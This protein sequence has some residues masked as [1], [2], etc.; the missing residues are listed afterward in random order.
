MPKAC[1]SAWGISVVL[2]R[3]PISLIN[4]QVFTFDPEFMTDRH[5]IQEWADF[6]L[7]Q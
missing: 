1:W 3:R 4:N 7:E 6:E 5:W 2:N